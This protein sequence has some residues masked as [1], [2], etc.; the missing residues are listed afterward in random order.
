MGVAEKKGSSFELQAQLAKGIFDLFSSA[1]NLANDS[2]KKLVDETVRTYMNNRRYFYLAMSCIKMKDHI[3]E[4]F[5]KTGQGYGKQIAYM[6][7]A[8]QALSAG[9]KDIVYYSIIY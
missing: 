6:S 4:E 1:Y 5:K 3:G 9:N 2:L 8:Y 7:L